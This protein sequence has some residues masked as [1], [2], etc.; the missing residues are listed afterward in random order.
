MFKGGNQGEKETKETKKRNRCSISTIL[1]ELELKD[2]RIGK[3]ASTST[4]TTIT[5]TTTSISTHPII[6]TLT[7]IF[8]MMM[9]QV[10]IFYFIL[11]QIYYRII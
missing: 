8:L 3:L 2:W 11:F 10:F 1:Y 4:S 7:T 9:H 5:I 6:H